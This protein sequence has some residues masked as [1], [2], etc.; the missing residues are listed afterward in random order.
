M[1]LVTSTPPPPQVKDPQKMLRARGD[2]AAAALEAVHAGLIKQANEVASI[3][4][5]LKEVDAQFGLA[6]AGGQ[7]GTDNLASSLR[8]VRSDLTGL[9]NQQIIERMKQESV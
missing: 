6:I 1:T 5:K 9:T 3:L 2:A 4:A 7:S 8:S